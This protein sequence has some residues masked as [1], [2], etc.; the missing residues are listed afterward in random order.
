MHVQDYHRIITEGIKDLPESALAEIADFVTFVRLRVRS[1]ASG[2]MDLYALLLQMERH[3]LSA[4]SQSHL[5]EE[6][7]DYAERYPLD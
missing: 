4:A 7:K 6:F 2:G 3:Q 5:E 1:S